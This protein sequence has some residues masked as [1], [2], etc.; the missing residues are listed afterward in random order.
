MRVMKA[1]VPALLLSLT[2]AVTASAER[3]E[4]PEKDPLFTFNLPSGWV[5][6]FKSGHY[7]CQPKGSD[8]VLSITSTASAAT[9]EDVLKVVEMV[10]G[11]AFTDTTFEEGSSNEANGIKFL[12]AG[13]TG[14]MDG[15]THK[16]A[17]VVVSPD[18][19]HYFSIY[20][21]GDE[22]ADKAH[23]PECAKLVQSIKA[24]KGDSSDK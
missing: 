15:K 9:A 5:G 24:K 7:L 12:G 21:V 19:D 20:W 6:A 11:A 22:A 14:M 10:L 13:G 2:L 3:I 23:G 18:G 16:L 4:F 1:L 8:F 17:V